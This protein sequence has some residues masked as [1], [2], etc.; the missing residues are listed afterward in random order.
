MSEAYFENDDGRKI[1]VADYMETFGGIYVHN[2]TEW[3]YEDMA[4][5]K[6]DLKK[7]M[8][9]KE[10]EEHSNPM[11]KMQ[12]IFSQFMEVVYRAITE[13]IMDLNGLWSIAK[14]IKLNQIQKKRN[15]ERVN[16]YTDDN[17]DKENDFGIFAKELNI[18]IFHSTLEVPIYNA[19]IN[20]SVL[21]EVFRLF[22]FTFRCDDPFLP[23]KGSDSYY[24]YVNP[25]FEYYD[26]IFKKDS[27]ANIFEAVL[28]IL[29]MDRKQKAGVGFQI[30]NKNQK[31]LKDTNTF[32]TSAQKL[33]E[34]LQSIIPLDLFKLFILSTSNTTLLTRLDTIIDPQIRRNNILENCLL[35]N[36]NNTCEKVRKLLTNLGEDPLLSIGFCK[37]VAEISRRK[38]G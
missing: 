29:N 25:F 19:E 30:L 26:N 3:Y 36:T 31:P 12:K 14:M 8:K 38:Q 15:G 34:K 20:D 7:N 1:S 27:E 9:R 22:Y 28:S 23:K 2:E 10:Q 37:L 5:R 11:Y 17:Y 32:I 21:H 24:G 16:C 6:I 4:G 18:N 33:V 35:N 13:H